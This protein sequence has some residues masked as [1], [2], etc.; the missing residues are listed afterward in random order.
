MINKYKVSYHR[1]P[2][3]DRGFVWVEI[4]TGKIVKVETLPG[5]EYTG[6]TGERFLGKLITDLSLYDL[7]FIDKVESLDEPKSE[8]N[9]IIDEIEKYSDRIQGYLTDL[10]N[11][12]LGDVTSSDV[13]MQSHWRGRLFAVPEILAIINRIR[14][15]AA[16]SATP[17]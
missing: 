13:M 4:S 5:K 7:K 12:K 15:Q 10:E 8:L 16:R 3:S 2:N 1:L 6:F 11:R 9:Q 17:R 14:C